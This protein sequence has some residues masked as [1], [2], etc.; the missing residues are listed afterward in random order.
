MKRALI[1]GITGQ[2]GSY[3]ADLLLQKGYEVH[4][5]IRRSSSFNTERIDHVYKDPHEP[6]ARLKLH[7]G[8]LADASSLQAIVTLVQPDEVYNLGAQ[9]HVRVSFDIPE[10]TGEVT[11]LGTIRMLEALRRYDSKCRFYQA[12]SSELYGKVVEVPQRESTPFHPRSPYA[13]AKAYS[14]YATVNY[15]EAYGMFASNGILFN[16]E[17]PR[18]GETFVTRKITRAVGRIKHGLQSALYLGNLDARRD[19]GHAQDYVEAMWLML[20]QDT[21]DD[22]V[23][24][25][26]EA[27]SVREFA[28][29]AFARAGL[30][31]G[32]FVKLDPK[33]LRPSEVDL[34]LSDPSKAR[35]KLRWTPKVSFVELVERM[36]DSDL[37]LAAREKRARG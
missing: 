35:E 33:Y 25:T 28:E 22:Y 8:D 31:Y 9:S 3:L 27:H 29:L 18:R 13:V 23:V 26:G 32:D 36:V 17:S 10:Y 19:W 11:A 20:Q 6:D 1:T 24:G 16:H 14:F 12:S 2:D 21:A 34:L 4:G 7:Y 15:R 30:D 5:I 37:E